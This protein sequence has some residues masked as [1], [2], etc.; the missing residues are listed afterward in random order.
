MQRETRKC[1]WDATETSCLRDTQ[2]TCG[3]CRLLVI[4]VFNRPGRHAEYNFVCGMAPSLP[5]A[6]STYTNDIIP[7]Q[8][9]GF[10]TAASNISMVHANIWGPKS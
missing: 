5:T 9:G 10:R 1:F 2:M 6:L 3:T 8:Q 7:N 4:R